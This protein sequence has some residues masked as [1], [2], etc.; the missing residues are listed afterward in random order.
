VTAREIKMQTGIE[1]VT[2]GIRRAKSDFAVF[3]ISMTETA[4]PLLQ[5]A[6]LCELESGIP[7]PI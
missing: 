2:S 7:P 3:L 4:F 6:R 1:N 5:V